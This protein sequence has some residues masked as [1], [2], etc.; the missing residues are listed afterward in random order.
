MKFIVSS[1][2]LLKKL[3]LIGGVLNSSNTLPILDDFL[4]VIKKGELSITASDLETTME[5][6]ISIEAKEDGM[7]AI[8]AKLLLDTLK[9]FPDQ[10]LTFTIDPSNFG[11]EISSDY[12]KS[13]PSKMFAKVGS[14]SINFFLKPVL[15][16]SIFFL[17]T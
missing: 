16:S 13:G 14:F 12:G 2:I 1:E 11:I 9:T 8:P 7:I 5:T 6:K 17:M 15:K 4:F 3:Q 10:P